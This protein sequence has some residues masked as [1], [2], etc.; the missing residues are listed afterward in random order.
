[1]LDEKLT[2]N[3]VGERSQGAIVAEVV[4]YGYTVLIPFGE[5]HRYDMVIEKDG[6][7]LRLQCKTG[8]YEN[9]VV[10][11]A[12][13]SVNWWNK[14]K[15]RYTREEIDYFAVYC[16]YTGKVYLVSVD[17]VPHDMGTL[18][19]EPTANNQAKGV[20]WAEDFEIDRVMRG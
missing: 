11:F 13:C 18:R 10:K 17:V 16:Q 2:P 15:K 5:A 20:R 6:Q 12:T 19:V 9:G 1:M 7:F 14:T 8:R 3:M 4:K